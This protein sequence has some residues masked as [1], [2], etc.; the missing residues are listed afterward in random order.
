[1]RFSQQFNLWISRF[2]GICHSIIVSTIACAN[3][4][5][6]YRPQYANGVNK[7]NGADKP[8]NKNIIS[9][10]QQALLKCCKKRQYPDLWS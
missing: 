3:M 7:V 2:S 6:V 8:I 10:A 9:Q 4:F 1:M 5:S